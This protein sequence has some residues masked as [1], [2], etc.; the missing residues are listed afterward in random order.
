MELQETEAIPNNSLLD[1]GQATDSSSHKNH[2][3][4]IDQAT[5]ANQ[6]RDVALRFPKG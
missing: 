1:M 3:S 6:S 4:H 2:T 5:N